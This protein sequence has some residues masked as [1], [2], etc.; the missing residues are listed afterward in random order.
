MLTQA[1]ART[2]LARQM[3]K[4]LEKA[5]PAREPAERST[6]AKMTHEYSQQS[7][8]TRHTKRQQTTTQAA[9]EQRGDTTNPRVVAEWEEEDEHDSNS[10]KT[11]AQL[12]A[13][14]VH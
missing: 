9:A 6:S 11:K 3:R 1:L 7:P 4:A 14:M 13:E 12:A 10:L 5:M 2:N 8:R